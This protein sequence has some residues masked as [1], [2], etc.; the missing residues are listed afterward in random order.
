M[1]SVIGS[2]SS[3]IGFALVLYYCDGIYQNQ[4]GRKGDDCVDE[5]HLSQAVERVAEIENG[6]YVQREPETSPSH[7]VFQPPPVL[8]SS[9]VSPISI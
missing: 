3:S 9:P 8:L 4:I 1:A 7:D 6:A 2:K 5:I